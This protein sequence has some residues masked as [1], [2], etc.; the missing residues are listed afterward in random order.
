MARLKPIPKGDS[1]KQGTPRHKHVPS[2][3][4]YPQQG[5]SIMLSS[6]SCPLCSFPTGN[7]G[8]GLCNLHSGKMV[9]FPFGFPFNYGQKDTST[10]HTPGILLSKNYPN[11]WG[12]SCLKRKEPWLS[13]MEKESAPRKA[14]ALFCGGGGLA[15]CPARAAAEGLHWAGVERAVCFSDLQWNVW[16]GSREPQ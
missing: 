14:P 9:C 2:S 5:G 15:R 1:S 10:T 11:P 13:R 16:I 12:N 6:H 3:F 7:V 4:G 8:F